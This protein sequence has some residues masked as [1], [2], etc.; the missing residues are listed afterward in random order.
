MSNEVQTQ[1][2]GGAVAALSGLKQGLANVTKT[3]PSTNTDPFLRM[4]KDG[5]WIYGADNVEVQE[6]SLWAINIMS[7]QHGYSCWTNYPDEK[8]KKNEIKGEVMVA[9][10]QPIPGRD[11]L[12]VYH[13]EDGHVCE[14]R[15]QYSFPLRCMNGDDTGVQVR[16]STTSVGGIGAVKDIIAAV[17]RQ[18]D[19]DPDNPIPIVLLQCDSYQNKKYGKTYFPI[20]LIKKWAPLAEDADAAMEQATEPTPEA[21][22]A[23]E[24][25][26][27][28]SAPRTEAQAAAPA[29]GEAPKRRRRRRPAA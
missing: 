11:T 8:D 6:K 12:A 18:L 1:P 17:M 23:V 21:K 2:A 20:F 27:P 19:R 10:T 13:D 16:Y 22:P 7:L 3:M 5:L 29:D 24:P 25:T 28:E 26:E 14:W 4:Q 15:E 9:A